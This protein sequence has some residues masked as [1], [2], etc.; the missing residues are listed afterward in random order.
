MQLSLCDVYI[1]LIFRV[2]DEYDGVCIATVL[3]P[4]VAEPRLTAQ[5]PQLQRYL[6]LLHRS[7]VKSDRWNSVLVEFSA[8]NC[9]H[10]CRLTC[11]L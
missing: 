7:V 1:A 3:L 4:A 10:Q 6:P 2:D 9:I 5:V 8:R 11:V